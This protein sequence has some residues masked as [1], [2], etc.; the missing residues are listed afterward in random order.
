MILDYVSAEHDINAYV[1]LGRAV[2][3]HWLGGTRK[4]PV[5]VGLLSYSRQQILERI[6][7]R[8]DCT[9]SGNARLLRRAQHHL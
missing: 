3:G 1:K 2:T 4:A 5:C 7:D 8:W 9:D 6:H